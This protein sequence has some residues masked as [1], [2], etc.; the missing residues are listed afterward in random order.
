MEISRVCC[1]AAAT[2]NCCHTRL[3]S[4]QIIIQIVNIVI[5]VLFFA[6]TEVFVFVSHFWEARYN[7]TLD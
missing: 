3:S 2:I 6:G 4:V 5:F 1:G 7:R